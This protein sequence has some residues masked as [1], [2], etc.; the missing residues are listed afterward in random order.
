MIDIVIP[1]ICFS[2]LYF[3]SL[4]KVNII[5]WKSIVLSTAHQIIHFRLCN[6]LISRALVLISNRKCIAWHA[7]PITLISVSSTSVSAEVCNE[8]YKKTFCFK[9]CLDFV[10][11]G[12]Q[13]RRIVPLLLF[14]RCRKRR[15]K[16]TPE[17]DSWA[18]GLPPSMSA[19]FLIAKLFR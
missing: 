8:N 18:I 11:C 14:Q 3:I 17:I 1:I 19:V 15:L 5:A 12:V 16:F 9:Y 6:A 13:D 7:L 2:K 4:L 10:P